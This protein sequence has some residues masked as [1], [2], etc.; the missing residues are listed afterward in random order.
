[1]ITFAY[2]SETLNATFANNIFQWTEKL[3]NI[4]AY[5][6]ADLKSVVDVSSLVLSWHGTAENGDYLVVWTE[7][8]MEDTDIPLRGV[9]ADMLVSLSNNKNNHLGFNFLVISKSAANLAPFTSIDEFIEKA[10]D[11]E[12]SV[13]ERDNVKLES[14]T[15]V[16]LKTRM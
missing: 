8:V 6:F 13:V 10:R 12:L 4:K 1:M 7:G 9:F 11:E 3:K 5:N 2:L 15:S 16:P 14:N